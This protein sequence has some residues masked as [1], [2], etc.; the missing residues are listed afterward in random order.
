MLETSMLEPSM[1]E[2]ARAPPTMSD[3]HFSEF[4]PIF[5]EK[6]LDFMKTKKNRSEI[7][8]RFP[9]VS[10]LD[11]CYVSENK[12]NRYS[13]NTHFWGGGDGGGDDGGG[14]GGGRISHPHP[15][16]IPSRPGIKYPVRVYPSLRHKN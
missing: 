16:H 7:T 5:V 6:I 11:L 13:P 8:S 10:Q 15:A 9:V 4:A 12:E 3:E 1:L 14:D 2:R